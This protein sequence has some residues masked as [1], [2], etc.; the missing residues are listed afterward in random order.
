MKGQARPRQR[1]APQ[2]CG[3]VTQLAACWELVT[4]GSA[5]SE[6]R[7]AVLSGEMRAAWW[8]ADRCEGLRPGTPG[9][10][11]LG[12]GEEGKETVTNCRAHA[13]LI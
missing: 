11:P 8:G 5:G 12:Q 3:V 9:T 10:A 1:P 2:S 13:S 7:A 6:H 4:G